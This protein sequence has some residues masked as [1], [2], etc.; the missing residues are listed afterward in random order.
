MSGDSL[1]IS[2]PIG[3]KNV[4]GGLPT[5]NQQLR[6]NAITNLWEF[7]IPAPGASTWEIIENY[8]E[9][10]ATNNT[11]TITHTFENSVYSEVVINAQFDVTS[12]FEL[13]L[14]V[15][16]VVGTAYR[17]RGWLADNANLTVIPSVSVG[18]FRIG[19]VTVCAT[20]NIVMVEIHLTLTP[21]LTIESLGGWSKARNN[22]TQS[23][24]M[25]HNN[26]GTWASITSLRLFTSAST[27]E[28]GSRITTYGIRRTV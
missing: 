24:Y 12:A 7:F 1:K 25:H 9:A 26:D 22:N 3:G 11:H 8:L 20:S 19:S 13:R 4:Q 10:G 16:G 17:S 28:D 2:Y 15:N 14:E 21:D 5:A 18:F 6:F 27:W 23:E